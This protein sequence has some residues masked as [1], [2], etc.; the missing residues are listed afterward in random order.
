MDRAIIWTQEQLRS[1]DAVGWQTDALVAMADVTHALLGGT[2]AVVSGLT[3]SASDPPSLVINLSAGQIFQLAA[4]DALAVGQIPQNLSQIVQQG[5]ASASTV[6]LST[7]GIGGGQSRYTLIQAQ[8]N[9]VDGVAPNDPNG[10][11]PPFYNAANPSSPIYTSVNTQRSGVVTIGTV[12]GAAATT[13]SEVPPSATAGWVGLYLI[14]LASGQTAVTSMQILVAGPS[15]GTNVPSNYPYAPILAGLLNSHHSG[16]PGQAPKINLATEVQ[17]TLPVGNL[18]PG[19]VGGLSYQGGWNANTNTPT[20]TS[21]VGTSGYFYVVT[22]AGTTALNGISSWSVGDWALFS[23]STWQ[24]IPAATNGVISFNTRTGAITLTSG[25]VTTALAYT[26][27]NPS[28]L[29]SAAYAATSAFDAS[30]AAA[31]ALTSAN[32]YTNT[33][34]AGET[35]RAQLAEALNSVTKGTFVTPTTGT[36]AYVFIQRVT[37]VVPAGG[38]TISALATFGQSFT[39]SDVWGTYFVLDGATS[40]HISA[41]YYG[42][43]GINI[44]QGVV[45]NGMYEFAL[46]A[47]THTIDVYWLGGTNVTLEFSFLNVF[48]AP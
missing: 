37:I 48:G 18:P 5:L 1:F 3:A 26:P 45:T 21:S 22:T 47:G 14:D 7:S 36:G 30:G 16:N 4:V 25:D 23:G 35:A 6:T 12:T 28:T 27:V 41:V 15:V 9:Q 13:G 19:V 8:F 29:G 17:G 40:S 39:S 32:S 46:S 10:G 20:L 42:F 43:P 44:P 38:S 31:T 24:K 2:T 33:Q 11:V 34:V